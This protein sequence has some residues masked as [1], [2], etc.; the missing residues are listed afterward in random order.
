MC[1]DVSHTSNNPNN[2]KNSNES[3]EMSGKDENSSD[4]P[5]KCVCGGSLIEHKPVFDPKGE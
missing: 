5:I 4:L 3:A 2:M 1:L